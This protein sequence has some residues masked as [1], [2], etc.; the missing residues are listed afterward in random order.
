MNKR[1]KKRLLRVGLLLASLVVGLLLCDIDRFKRIN[2]TLGHGV[3]DELLRDVTNELLAEGWKR[4]LFNLTGVSKIDSSGIGELV[5]GVKLAE[6]FES[7]I[8]VLLSGGRVR[9]VLELTD[10]WQE[11]KD[12]YARI[13]ELVG[14]PG[15]PLEFFES[16]IDDTT[17]CGRRDAVDSLESKDATTHQRKTWQECTTAQALSC[18]GPLRLIGS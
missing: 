9:D 14:E 3:G 11:R 15:V 5:A 13:P 2:D 16:A 10:R 18:S 6:R 17:K 1:L 8:K 4:I 12:V 7:S